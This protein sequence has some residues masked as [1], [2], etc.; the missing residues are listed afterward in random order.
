MQLENQ[1][2]QKR[3][4][5]AFQNNL[6]V[7]NFKYTGKIKT[8]CNSRFSEKMEF[9]DDALTDTSLLIGA[10]GILII[11]MALLRLGRAR[12]PPGP[13]KW[14]VLGNLPQLAGDRMF[15]EKL[16]DLRK[17]YGDNVFITLGSL[18]IL[19]VYGHDLVKEVIGPRDDDFKYRPQ[20]LIEIQKLELFK[21]KYQKSIFDNKSCFLFAQTC[22]ISFREKH[23]G[24]NIIIHAIN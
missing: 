7:N 20:W 18:K 16:N 22:K 23:L 8:L 2:K 15:Y 5:I 3:N 9:L 14:P 13:R 10:V 21:G 6:F 19:V 1:C 12:L 24:R 4:R 17:Q 11:T